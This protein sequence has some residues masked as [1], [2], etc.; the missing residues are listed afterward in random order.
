MIL[1]VANLK[2]GTKKTTSAAFLAHVLAELGRSV[3]CI[4]GDGE[5]ESLAQWASLGEWSIPV[6][7]A[8][9]P[10]EHVPALLAS[11]VDDVVID[12]PPMRE[13]RRTVA[14]AL[15][16]ATHVLV[17][18]APSTIEADRVNVVRDF[19]R[20]TVPRDAPDTAVVLVGTIPHAASTTVMR[21]YL[22]AAGHRVLTT[23]VPRRERFAQAFPGPINRAASGPYADV[24]GELLEGQPA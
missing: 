19:V 17:P 22:T 23:V 7:V 5:N 4:D 12:T 6:T 11:G 16:V 21:D 18:V 15:R 24:L 9:D 3:H 20:K 13:A 10:H 2:G 8:H 14:S 1:V